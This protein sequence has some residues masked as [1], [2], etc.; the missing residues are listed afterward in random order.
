MTVIGHDIIENCRACFCENGYGV[1]LRRMG[2]I[3]VCTVND[4]HKYRVENGFMKK[5]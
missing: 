4:A 1:K 5:V 2:D 3:Y